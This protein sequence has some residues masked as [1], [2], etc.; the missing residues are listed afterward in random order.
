MS[1]KGQVITWG[2][3]ISKAKRGKK[4][5]KEYGE[6]ISKAIK[7]SW[8][9]PSLRLKYIDSHVGFIPTEQHKNNISKGLKEAYRNGTRKRGTKGELKNYICNLEEYK[10]WRIQIFKRDDYTCINC[11]IRGGDLHVH[12]IKPFSIILK[13]FLS[14]YSNFSVK[15]DKD[16]L[17]LLAINYSAFWDINN[18]QTLCKNCHSK[19]PTFGS[20]CYNKI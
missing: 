9:N 2:D 13:D 1:K 6:K 15:T 8:K 12:H 14:E 7:K 16:K 19:T 3:K 11:R 5:P 10:K 17:L 4:F 20:K 18:G